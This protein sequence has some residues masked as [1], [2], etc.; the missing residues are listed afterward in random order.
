MVYVAMVMRAVL[1]G[2]FSAVETLPLLLVAF[3]PVGAF[4]MAGLFRRK[5]AAL[6]SNEIGF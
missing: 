4:L 3:L 1:A 2:L 6:K 5:V